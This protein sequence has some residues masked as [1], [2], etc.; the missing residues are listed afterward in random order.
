MDDSVKF[1]S[2]NFISTEYPF[3]ELSTIKPG[4][5]ALLITESKI[6]AERREDS[7]EGASSR[8]DS[9][10]SEDVGVYD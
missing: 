5:I 4:Y 6:L 2:G 10:T 3:S 1:P 9:S 7:I 8:L